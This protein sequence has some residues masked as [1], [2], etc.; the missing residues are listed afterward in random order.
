MKFDFLIVG[1]GP[2]GATFARKAAEAGRT[3]LVID[4]R[5]HVA[6][7]C[8]TESVD[9]I[10][11]HRFGPHI[12]HTANERIW[13]F[14]NRFTRF[15]DYRH[16]AQ[17]RHNG[18]DYSFPINLTTLRQLWGVESAEEARNR[19]ANARRPCLRPRSMRDWLLS[20]VGEEL[21]EIFFRGYSTKQWGRDP[22]ALPA[23][24]VR[25]IPIRLSE[26]DRYFGDH[27]R[28]EG[29]PIGGYTQLFR[30]M[31]DHGNVYVEL[32]ADYFARR[33]DWERR[34]RRI[35]YSGKLDAYFDYELGALAYRSLRFVEERRRGQ[36]QDVAMVNYADQSVPY[37]RTVEHKHFEPTDVR[38]TIVTREYPEDHTPENDPYYPIRDAANVETLRRYRL[39]ARG[40]RTVFGGRLGSYRYYNMDQVIAQAITAADR[41]LGLGPEI[42]PSEKPIGA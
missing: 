25:R 20:Q 26:D 35:I 24:I 10:H 41:E 28:F 42:H 22:S 16:K 19:L 21:Y 37:T 33:D 18:V 17:V 29:I 3:S 2:F 27:I 23:S 1:A 40:T 31:L 15:N 32:E 12:F 7:N 13:R 11:V 39:L 6:G 9:G 4:R 36:A 38:H 34:A 14:V 5:S 30:R 8:Y